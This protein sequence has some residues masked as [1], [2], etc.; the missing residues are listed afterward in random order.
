MRSPSSALS[1]LLRSF[2]PAAFLLL[3]GARGCAGARCSSSNPTVEQS[4][5]GFGTPPK[6]WVEIQNKCPMCP[7]INIHVRC[8]NFSQALVSPKLFKVIAYDDCVVN[9][10]LPLAPLQKFS[11]TYSHPK[12]LLSL[13]TWSFQCE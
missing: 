9:G 10:G 1:L 4:Q 3:H 8:G 11:F 13:K 12:F 5:V 2:L 6:F 7:A